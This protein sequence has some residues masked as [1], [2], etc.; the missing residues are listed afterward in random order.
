M[1]NCKSV[2]VSCKSVTGFQESNAA[3]TP[4]TDLKPNCL[5]N[6]SRASC[7]YTLELIQ[8]QFQSVSKCHSMANEFQNHLRIRVIILALMVCN[9]FG[10][11]GLASA[12]GG[13]PDLFR[14]PRFLPICSDLRSLFSGMPRFVPICSDLFRFVFRANQNKSGKL[15]SSDPFCKSPIILGWSVRLLGLFPA[16]G[17]SSSS[18][19]FASKE[20]PCN[21]DVE[22]ILGSK[23]SL[24]AC[25]LTRFM[26]LAS[27]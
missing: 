1:G 8:S 17:Q 18:P 6:I 16:E 2:M 27:P 15:L 10:A 14:F 7:H 9:H 24:E 19:F 3:H 20:F 26:R 5:Q 21:G 22:S 13:Y 12:E 4:D 25:S 23:C 11:P